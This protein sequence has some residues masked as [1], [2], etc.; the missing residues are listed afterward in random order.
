[1]CGNAVSVAL[2][3]A[4][5]D[6]RTFLASRVVGGLSEGN[7]Q[8]AM[9]MATDVSDE[10]QR[11]GTM[12]M[13]GICFSVAFTF[14]PAI[15]AALSRWTVV[16]ANPF[17]ASAGVSLGLILTETAYL[18]F[19]LPETL[20][21]P[22]STTEEPTVADQ[23]E[24]VPVEKK[25]NGGDVPSPT[26]EVRNSKTVLHITHFLFILTFAGIEF[27]LPFMTYDLFGFDSIGNGR[28]LGLIGIIASVLQGT[29]T[30]RVRP[31]RV[32]QVGTASCAAAFWILSTV[33]SLVGLYVAAGLL[34]VTSATVVTGLNSLS[35]L[36]ARADERGRVLGKHRSSGQLGRTLGPVLF[37][38]LYWWAGRTTAYRVGM[39]GMVGV[40]GLVFGLLVNPTTDV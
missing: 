33:D 24:S 8:L 35:S 2:W 29:F 19:C 40:L 23:P 21:A 37:C 26:T 13:I 39:T 5:T 27:S 4:A 20:P 30:R 9:A 14:G 22:A 12:A 32:V 36:E 10:S 34:A 28:L 31:L 1:M 38:S 18:Y 17:A 15:G 7:V 3:L 25:S 16:K 11:S 6:F